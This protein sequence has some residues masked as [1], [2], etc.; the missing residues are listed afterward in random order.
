MVSIVKAIYMLQ[1]EVIL[2]NANFEDLN[3][4][5][6]GREKLKVNIQSARRY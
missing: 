4:N 5:L 1:R 6:E 2:P 3:E